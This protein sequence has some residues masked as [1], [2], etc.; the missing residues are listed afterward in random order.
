MNRALLIARELLAIAQNGLWF[1]K[2]AFDHERFTRVRELGSAL[3]AE[4]TG[5]LQA[6]TSITFEQGYATPKVDVRGAVFRDDRLL[7]VRERSDGLWTLPGGW[8]D[9]NDSPATAIAREIRE[10]SG[11]DTC[12]VKL[13]ALYDRDKHPH[14]A[15]AFHVYKVFFLCEIVGGEARVGSETDA[16]EFFDCD[17]LPELS[18][19]RVTR[20]QLLTMFRHHRDRLAP[21]EFD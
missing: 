3:M 12:V 18:L 1:T 20:G 16:V 7:L 9:V 4:E 17:S 10:E 5:D 14:P 6:S 2:D 15:M 11:F 21:T 19:A 8:A 13:V